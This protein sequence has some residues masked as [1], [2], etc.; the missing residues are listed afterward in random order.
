MFAN[1]ESRAFA[2]HVPFY[3]ERKTIYGQ[4]I[5]YCICT[6]ARRCTISIRT[7]FGAPLLGLGRSGLEAFLEL[8]GTCP[9]SSYESSCNVTREDAK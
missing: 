5:M 9:W 7:A 6:P 1:A 4:R 2:Y 3:I 8:V